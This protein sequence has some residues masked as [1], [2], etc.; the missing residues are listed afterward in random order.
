LKQKNRIFEIADFNECP[1]CKSKVLFKD[2]D[3]LECG[4]C[5]LVLTQ[6]CC[7]TK[8]GDIM[9]EESIEETI[10]KKRN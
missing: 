10:R 6:N 1:K 4:N 5:G 8:Q 7:Y 9:N 3:S 2:K